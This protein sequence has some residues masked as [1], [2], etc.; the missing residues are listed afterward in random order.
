MTVL[1]RGDIILLAFAAWLLAGC[2]APSVP[3]DR[4]AADVKTIGVVT[5]RVPDGAVVFLASNVGQS[6]GLI[7]A[8]IEA[9]MQAARESAFQDATADQGFV[10]RDEVLQGLV[11]GLKDKGY[12][13]VPITTARFGSEFL[14]AYPPTQGVDAYLDVVVAAY[15]YVAAGIGPSTPYRLHVDLRVRLVAPN[16]KSVLMQDRVVY[17]QIG[18]LGMG[19]TALT[20]PPDE[21]FHYA[22]F[23][24]L[25]AAPRDAIVG[26]RTAFEASV[27]RLVELLK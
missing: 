21:R 20:L 6:F 26:L 23:D 3:F 24:N 19:S 10:P 11:K 2:V 8:L 4:Q 22:S 9:G 7:G 15:G 17:N 5:P 14:D 16:Y 27:V 12:E 18:P 1:R 13:I 25:K